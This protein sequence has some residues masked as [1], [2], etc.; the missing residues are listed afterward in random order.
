MSFPAPSEKQARILWFSVTAVA[1]AVT[2]ALLGLLCWGAGWVV[3]QLTTILLPLAVATILSYLLDPVVDFFERHKVPRV[4]AIL[5]VFFLAVMLVAIFLSTVVP[6]VVVEVGQ[7]VQKVPEYAQQLRG[8][9]I[10]TAARL[11]FGP[12]LQEYWEKDFGD[13][14]QQWLT[15]ALPAVSGWLTQ[16]WSQAASLVSLALGFALVPVYLFY[17]LLEK[18][19]IQTTWKNYVPFHDSWLKDEII[20]VITAI[21]GYLIVFFRGQVLV[22]TCV[23]TLLSTGF[24]LV[25]LDYAVLLGVMAGVLGIV[26]YLGVMMSLLPA[27]GIAAV[28]FR[29]WTH[30]LL[31][32]GV[33]ALVHLA[34]GLAISPRIMGDRVG[35]HPLIIIIAVMVGTTLLGGIIGGVLAIPLTAALRVLM[36]RYVWKKGTDARQAG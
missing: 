30:P 2:L 25:G 22:A 23:G 17:F 20:F 36:F 29:D 28:Q 21:N 16:H 1:L 13:T 7:L 35:L 19:G 26:P 3:K 4:R 6:Q 11:P 32:L 33:F 18:E 14:A 5:L 24:L 27:L 12:R 31:V 10:D 15:S 9:V 34:E 8:Y